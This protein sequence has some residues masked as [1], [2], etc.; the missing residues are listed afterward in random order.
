MRNKSHRKLS[1]RL[2]ARLLPSEPECPLLFWSIVQ[3]VCSWSSSYL[4]W[5][6]LSD[7]NHGL[8]RDGPRAVQFHARS[9]ASQSPVDHRRP[10][11]V[12]AQRMVSKYNLRANSKCRASYGLKRTFMATP[13]YGQ[14]RNWMSL[15][16]PL[17]PR[18]LTLWPGIHVPHPRSENLV[19]EL[20]I[21]IRTY[22]RFE[23]E[24]SLLIFEIAVFRPSFWQVSFLHNI[25]E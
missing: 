9:N 2:V 21:D 7:G 1:R 8:I 19:R 22:Q 11:A 3:R 17:L 5:K 23:R 24:S 18:G 4:P 16:P 25:S 20:P 13:N 10:S 15:R 6:S 12:M 14:S